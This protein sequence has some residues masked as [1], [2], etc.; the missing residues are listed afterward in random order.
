MIYLDTNVV[1][2][3]A[4]AQQELSSSA[5]AAINTAATLLVSPLVELEI[6]YLYEIGRVQRQGAAVLAHLAAVLPLRRCDRSFAAVVSAACRI[7]WTR[8]PFDRLITAQAA[9]DGDTL[10][11][12]DKIIR[13]NYAQARW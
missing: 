3:L 10:L 11:T 9:V 5:V 7:T 6:E 13:S 2:W 4:G 1:L 8:D 12:R